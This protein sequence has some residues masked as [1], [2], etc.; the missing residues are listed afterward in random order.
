MNTRDQGLRRVGLVTGGLL[1]ATA[2][3]SLAFAAVA[4]ADTNA[5]QEEQQL[6]HV[7]G[8]DRYVRHVDIGFYLDWNVIDRNLVVRYLVFRDVFFRFTRL[9]RTSSGSGSSST[10]SGTSSTPSVSSGS[11]SAQSSSGGS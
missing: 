8:S 6:E 2:V 5:S 10:S 7:D 3:G 11:G 9:P 1:S 4:K